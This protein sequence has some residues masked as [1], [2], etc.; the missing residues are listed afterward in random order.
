MM[1]SIHSVAGLVEYLGNLSYGNIFFIIIASGHL[2]PIPESATLILLGYISAF[3]KLNIWSV[4]AVAVLATIA[5]D[6]VVY[7]ICLGGSELAT[8]LSK[9][10]KI[11]L[12]DKYRNAE[13]KHLFGLVFASHFIPGWRFANPVIAGVTQMPWKKFTLYSLISSLVYAPLYTSLGF[14]FHG[15][16]LP[17]VVFLQ[18][19]QHV[20]LWVLAV[21][22]ATFIIV[23]NIRSHAKE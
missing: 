18:S 6:L 22:L 15:R 5:I 10:I 17:V 12:L 16:V 9:R 13:E 1:S 7:A 8:R 11:E 14:F 19:L 23:Y 3:G 20:I 4:L 21:A 2:L